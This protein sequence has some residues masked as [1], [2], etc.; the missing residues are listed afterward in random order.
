[1]L[2]VFLAKGD[3]PTDA[4]AVPARKPSSTRPL[5]MGCTDCKLITAAI[6]SPL[7]QVSTHIILESQTGGVPG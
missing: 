6:A 2:M 1:M 5:S 4:T 7:T 3:H